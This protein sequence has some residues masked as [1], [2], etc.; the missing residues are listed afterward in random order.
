VA[1]RGAAGSGRTGGASDR[2]LDLG[3]PG[4]AAF[5]SIPSAA[6]GG[7]DS[8]TENN[9]ATIS[10]WAFGADAQPVAQWG[11]LAQ[12]PASGRVI[13]AHT[14]WSDGTFYFDVSSNGACCGATVRISQNVPDAQDYEG[15][16]NHY[17]FLKNEGST[18]IYL[19][20]NL[21]VESAPANVMDPIA[22]ITA[23][24]IGADPAGGADY[25][26][27]YDDFTIFD[28]ALT[29]DEIARIADGEAIPSAVLQ[30]GD[31]DSSGVIDAA[32]FQALASNL[33][34]HLDREVRHA[35]GDFDLNGQVNLRD[36]RAFKNAFPGAFAAATG[37]PEP[38]SLL[39]AVLAA[40]LLLPLGLRCSKRG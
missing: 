36:F 10:F 11:F 30:Q 28:V 40:G 39:L 27:Q 9:T 5:V 22:Q 12:G 21:L 25:A 24:A 31:F 38:G 20:G 8:L 13:G 18:A 34:V 37:V 23:F 15:R 29:P 26:G 33:G 2:S 1:I 3:G 32:D 4:N 19:N 35:D 7:L 16:W 14:P 6:T 17:A